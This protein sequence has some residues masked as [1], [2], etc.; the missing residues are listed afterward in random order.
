MTD[1]DRLARA[2]GPSVVTRLLEIASDG[3]GCHA[4]VHAAKAQSVSAFDMIAGAALPFIVKG[5]RDFLARAKAKR[6]AARLAWRA[7]RDRINALPRRSKGW[8][9]HLRRMKAQA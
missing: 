8:R 2:L 5:V 6:Y 9:R 4:R 7:E 1:A 3:C